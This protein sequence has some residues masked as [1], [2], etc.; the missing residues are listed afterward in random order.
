MMGRPLRYHPECQDYTEAQVNDQPSFI[1]RS[2]VEKAA[3]E[4]NSVPEAVRGGA[5]A[6]SPARAGKR[7]RH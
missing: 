1:C 4:G 7:A 3:R 5:P 2:C 6:P